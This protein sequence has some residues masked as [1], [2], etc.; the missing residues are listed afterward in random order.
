MNSAMRFVN[1]VENGVASQ[2]AIRNEG[3]NNVIFVKG[4]TNNG[5]LKF[6]VSVDGGVNWVEDESLVFDADGV[7]V[8]HKSN[9]II[10]PV[11]DDVSDSSLLVVKLGF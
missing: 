3:R 9:A 2:Q 8:L 5:S 4:I 6:A 1:L 11:L 10:K 7:V